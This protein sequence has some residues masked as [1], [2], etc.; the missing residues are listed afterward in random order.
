M[1]SMQLKKHWKKRPTVKP[2][3]KNRNN[4]L[5][6]KEGLAMGE[7]EIPVILTRFFV[8]FLQFFFYNNNRMIQEVKKWSIFL[9]ENE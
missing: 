2:V 4:I 9:Q 8:A 5:L 1:L 3:S 7:F 6:K